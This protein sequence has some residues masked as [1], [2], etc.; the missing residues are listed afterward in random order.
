VPAFRRVAII[1]NRRLECELLKGGSG[2]LC[3]AYMCGDSVVPE[4]DGVGLPF[5]AGLVI[6]ALVD[7]VVQES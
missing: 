3:D 4:N 7:V 6:R 5:D 2:I 1:D